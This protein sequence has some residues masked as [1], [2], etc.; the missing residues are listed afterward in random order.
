[1]LEKSY[2]PQAILHRTDSRIGIVCEILIEDQKLFNKKLT[3]ESFS[4]LYLVKCLIQCFARK[5]QRILSVLPASLVSNI[6]FG[7]SYEIPIT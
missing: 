5:T 6:F 3:G 7:G 2:F 4:N 1:M